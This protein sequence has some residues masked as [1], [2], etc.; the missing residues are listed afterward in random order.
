MSEIAEYYK[1]TVVPGL[2]TMKIKSD[3]CRC[4]YK[5]KRNFFHLGTFH[6]SQLS[7]EIKFA[8]LQTDAR[9][10]ANAKGHL[11]K[12][13]KEIVDSIHAATAGLK[14]TEVTMRGACIVFV[15]M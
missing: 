5:G 12:V 4:Q 10:A 13:R 14:E 6:L 7:E 9:T 11:Q 3:G 8:A 2:S 15:V 1:R